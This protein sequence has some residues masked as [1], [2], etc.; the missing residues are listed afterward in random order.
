MTMTA[1][2]VAKL[3]EECGELLQVC[4]KRLASYHEDLH[5]DGTN[6]RERMEEEM[7]DVKAAIQFVTDKFGLN[8]AFIESRK[9]EKLRLF[10]EWDS[11]ADNNMHGVDRL[12]E[13]KS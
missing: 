11:H 6:L 10:R 4:G 8:S 7:G 5:W 12:E 13:A 9:F 2:G 1:G 3:I